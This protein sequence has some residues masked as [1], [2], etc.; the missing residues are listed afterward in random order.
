MR[1]TL[2][3]VAAAAS[4]SA[5]TIRHS[6]LLVVAVLINASTNPILVAGV[7]AGNG[8]IMITLVTPK[9]AGTLADC[10]GKSV[11]ALAQQFGALPAAV[12]TLRFANAAA[13][14]TATSTFCEKSRSRCRSSVPAGDKSRFF[15][16][17]PAGVV[18]VLSRRR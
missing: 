14:Q 12:T 11:S 9:F 18:L 4:W 17:P 13:L 8:D 2:V 3:A 16:P 6:S 1:L 5:L 10:Q 15:D 7:Q